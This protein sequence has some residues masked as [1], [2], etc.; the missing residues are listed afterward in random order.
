MPDDLRYSRILWRLASEY[1]EVWCRPVLLGSYVLLLVS[2]EQAWPHPV[3]RPSSCTPA[4]Y[5][6]LIE[7]G[8]IIEV[9]GGYTVKGYQ[10]A[11]SARSAQASSAANTRHGKGK[12]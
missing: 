12:P 11:R 2:V 8:L 5:R 6:R 10:K 7:E 9:P 1:P 3:A 4:A